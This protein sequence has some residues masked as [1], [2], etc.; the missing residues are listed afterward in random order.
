MITLYTFGPNFGLPDPSPF[1]M[2]TQVQLQMA[3]LAYA[4]DHTGL[5]RAPKG[6]L[7][8]IDD[9]G[10]VVADSAFIR[11]YIERTYAVDLDRGLDTG[12]RAQA[13]AVERMLEDHL[14]W[15][16]IHTRW[17]MDENFAK[18][19]A[20]FFDS[21]PAAARD[22]VR[23]GARERTLAALHGHGLGRHDAAEIG[24]LGRKTLDSLAAVLGDQAYLFGD[25][26]CGADATALGFI[27]S[28]LCPLFES[29]MRQAAEANANLIAYRD[30]LMRRYYPE[31]IASE[32][33][34]DREL[35][36][37]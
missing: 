15:V 16:M 37:A 23:A 31:F 26:P 17:A 12:Q 35:A 28:V 14:Y 10:T 19:P 7:P 5:G 24:A 9:D 29:P 22:Q 11:D 2:K 6:K 25:R 4:A 27:A 1:A 34:L 20:R 36:N 18:G 21:A 32:A 13:W 33:I 3:G 8:Y 30:R